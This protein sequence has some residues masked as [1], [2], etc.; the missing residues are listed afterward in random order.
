[1]QWWMV[2]VW[3]KLFEKGQTPVSVHV[4]IKSVFWIFLGILPIIFLTAKAGEEARVDG[5]V[6]FLNYWYF[7][8]EIEPLRLALWC[9]WVRS[10]SK[11]RYGKASIFAYYTHQLHCKTLSSAGTCCSSSPADAA[12]QAASGVGSEFQISSVPCRER[13]P[14]V[15]GA[16]WLSI[17]SI[18]YLF[19]TDLY[20]SERQREIQ[21][22][23]DHSPIGIVR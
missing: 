17:S 4:L 15:L 1:M 21:I 13:V 2:M 16:L 3:W 5:L 9:R 7:R 18:I 22:L 20:N 8:Y 6:S 11:N 10:L 14:F 19:D 23:S 12:R